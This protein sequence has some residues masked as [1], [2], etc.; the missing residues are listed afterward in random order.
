[1]QYFKDRIESSDNYYPCNN[2][3]NK[4]NCGLSHIYNWMKLFVYFYN[5]EMRNETLSL[6]L[7]DEPT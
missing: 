7:G 6:K 4:E 1:M 5:S 2:N 3:N